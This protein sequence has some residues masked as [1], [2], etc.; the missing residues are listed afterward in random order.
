M[1]ELY[2][3]AQHQLKFVYSNAVF[4]LQA[5]DFG[6]D[7]LGARVEGIGV[8]FRGFAAFRLTLFSLA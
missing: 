4:L 8:R 6:K 7:T 5:A 2:G 1:T 3:I